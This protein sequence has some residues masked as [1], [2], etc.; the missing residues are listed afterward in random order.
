MQLPRVHLNLDILRDPVRHVHPECRESAPAEPKVLDRVQD[1]SKSW[2]CTGC[3]RAF[4][5]K[6]ELS[7]HLATYYVFLSQK[8]KSDNKRVARGQGQVPLA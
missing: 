6:D 8:K 5:T 2:I 1:A 7:H 4:T 3:Y